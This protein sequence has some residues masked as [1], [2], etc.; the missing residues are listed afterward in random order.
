MKKI[1]KEELEVFLRKHE[2]WL[3]DEPGGERA[4]LRG[5]KNVNIPIACP[6]K[7]SFIP[8]YRPIISRTTR[9]AIFT[10]P[11]STSILKIISPT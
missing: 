10:V 8:P 4:N 11:T 3:M 6:E 2:L 7:G 1:T 9:S 5:A